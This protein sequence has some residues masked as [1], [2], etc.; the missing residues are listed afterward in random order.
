MTPLTLP[1]TPTQVPTLHAD[2]AGIRAYAAHLFTAS[3]QVDD[4][5]GFAAGTARLGDWRGAAADAYR[6]ALDPVGRRA[7]A[8]SLALRDVARRVEAHADT[9]ERLLADHAVL[10]DRRRH[11]VAAIAALRERAG[12]PDTGSAGAWQAEADACARE[13]DVF[14]TDVASWAR[15]LATAEEAVRRA[16]AGVLTLDQVERRWGGVADPADG[17]LAT[18]PG[19]AASAAEV[20]AWWAGLDH[21][22]RSALVAAAP[23]LVGNRDGLPA[24]V[25]DRANR[26][27]LERDLAEWGLLVELGRAT[28]DERGCLDNAR[29]AHD[30]LAAAAATID[31]VTGEPAGAQLYA[32]DPTAFGGDGAVAVAVGDLDTADD[33]AVTVPGLGTDGGSAPYLATRAST[34]FEA[35]RF[36][37]GTRSNATLAWIG[38]DAPDNPPWATDGDASGVLDEGLAAQGGERLADTLDGLR[39]SRGGDPAHLTAI[40]HSYGSTTLGHAAHD[41]GVPVDDLVFVGSPGVGGDTDDAG[42]TG[43]DPQHVWAGANSRDP[44]ADLAN[45]GAVHLEL[46]GGLGLGDDPAEDDF[47]AQRFRAESTTRADDAAGLDAFADHGKYFD[48]DTES[49]YNLAQIVTDHPGR[50]LLAGPVHDPWYAGPQ[51]PEFDR[52]PTSPSTH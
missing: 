40:G 45:H 39:A 7:D 17:A 11:L 48:P 30:A 13:V 47:G 41:E 27:A 42:D 23:D 28:A 31:P 15:E 24:G 46:V 8:A 37:D 9:V 6:S 43:V 26:L 2:P 33:V 52:T 4:L 29:A 50:V 3:V 5:G 18:M 34:L 25:R 22:A 49:L 51:D 1:A 44:V 35:A 36:V 10:A 12:A 19:V 21:A 16:L 32:Y 38:Y 14:A 20:A